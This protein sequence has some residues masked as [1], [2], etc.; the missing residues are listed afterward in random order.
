M[1]SDVFFYQFYIDFGVHFKVKKLFEI[2]K[3]GSRKRTKTAEM[4]KRRVFENMR[5][6]DLEHR[7]SKEIPR[8]AQKLPGTTPES[9]Q[10]AI[11][12]GIHF[13]TPISQDFS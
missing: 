7:T 13:R 12:K 6:I 1:F 4:T 11:K 10:K 2:S 5:S 3:N 9:F 8:K